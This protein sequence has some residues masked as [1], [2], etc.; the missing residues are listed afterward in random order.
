[1]LTNGVFYDDLGGQFYA[2]RN[3]D[4]TRQRALDQLRQIA[5]TSPATPFKQLGERESPPQRG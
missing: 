2:K 1:M 4:K 5:T 3:P